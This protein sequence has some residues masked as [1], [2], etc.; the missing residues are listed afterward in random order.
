MLFPRQ[1]VHRGC[2]SGSPAQLSGRRTRLRWPSDKVLSGDCRFAT[3]VITSPT[4]GKGDRASPWRGGEHSLDDAPRLAAW[5][6]ATEAV[7][8]FSFSAAFV[9]ASFFTSSPPACFFAV[10]ATASVLPHSF[11]LLPTPLSCRFEARHDLSW[12]LL[13]LGE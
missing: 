10:F 7:L 11:P 13:L 4:R 6:R 5:R 8:H 9:D 3:A 12:S 1:I 2:N